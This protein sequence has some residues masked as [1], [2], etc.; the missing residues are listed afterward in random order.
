LSRDQVILNSSHTHTGPETDV[1]RHT[2]SLDS[3]ELKKIENYAQ[4]LEKAI[5]KLVGEA[6][7]T[8][9]PVKLYAENGISR[10]QVN[11]RN[12]KEASL[13]PTTDLKGP[14]DYAVPVIKVENSAG[15]LKAIAFGYACHPTVLS[16]YNWSGDYAGFAQLELEKIYP[17]AT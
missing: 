17:G 2:F 16:D 5:I 4:S 10:F 8:K 7:E 12:N 15:E 13:T 3:K 9:E 11:R 14:N 6:M 1:S